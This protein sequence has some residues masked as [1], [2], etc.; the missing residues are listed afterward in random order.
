VQEVI[1][2]QGEKEMLISREG[3]L[4]TMI[5]QP[6]EKVDMSHSEFLR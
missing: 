6:V 2:E 4:V 1:L 3:K 5:N